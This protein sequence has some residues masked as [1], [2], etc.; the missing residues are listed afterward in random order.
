[1][2]ASYAQNKVLTVTVDKP[3]GWK[4]LDKANEG[5]ELLLSVTTKLL[6]ILLI[7]SILSIK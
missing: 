2:L 3:V 4:T 7:V 1:M 6:F 5:D